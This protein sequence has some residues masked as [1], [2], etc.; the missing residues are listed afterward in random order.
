MSHLKRLNAPK[1]WKIKRKGLKYILKQNP[2]PHSL[3]ICIPLGT[4]LRDVM[5]IATNLREVKNI[6]FW[7]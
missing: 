1:M 2:G 7:I 3:K 4:L 5:S 6:L